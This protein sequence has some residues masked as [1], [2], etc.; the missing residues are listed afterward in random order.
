MEFEAVAAAA[1]ETMLRDL[2]VLL[3]LGS[4]TA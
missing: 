3:Y 4:R 2:L 1:G